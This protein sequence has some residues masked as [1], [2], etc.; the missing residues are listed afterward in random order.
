MYSFFFQ[1]YTI[2]VYIFTNH[3][4]NVCF[5]ILITDTR[6]GARIVL[7]GF[8]FPVDIISSELFKTVLPM[9]IEDSLAASQTY[10]VFS[11]PFKIINFFHCHPFR[12]FIP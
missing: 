2:C 4:S 3:E 12:T 10:N 9:D 11:L 6:E 5:H 1:S 7:V 8:M